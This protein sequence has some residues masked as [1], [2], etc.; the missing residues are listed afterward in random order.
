MSN[1]NM[2]F[3]EPGQEQ[4]PYAPRPVNAAPR[5]EQPWQEQPP[6]PREDEMEAGGSMGYAGEK[7]GVGPNA[8][9][10][11]QRRRR[12]W[13]W[14]AL[15]VLLLIILGSGSSSFLARFGV[16]SSAQE[17]RVFAFGN[18]ITPN[19][20][21]TN[22]V[23]SISVHSGSGNQVSVSATK[24]SNGFLGNPNDVQVK[25]AQTADGISV[26]VANNSNFFNSESVNFDVTVPNNANLTLKTDTGS[27]DVNSVN[28]VLSLTSDTG[29]ISAT[30]DSLTGSSTFQSDTGSVTFNGEIAQDQ[31][32]Q[33]LFR[34]NTGAVNV[35]LPSSSQF[36]LNA[37][38][39]TGSCDTSFP[40]VP[41]Q[42]P[43]VT[44][45]HMNADVGSSPAPTVTLQTDTGS[46]DLIQGP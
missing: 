43:D 21:I 10:Q 4:E 32:Q 1:Q 34:T 30:A 41:I 6:F 2:Q 18:G 13:P 26:A 14:I 27:I 44:G 35:T 19:V 17:A 28:G 23:G 33:Y 11:R 31:G 20:V 24:Q 40:G 46:V 25:Y 38:T 3:H 8:H 22:D 37:S 45:C 36:H 15:V 12:A 29:S 16:G 9:R 42:H 39:S 5:E 7:I